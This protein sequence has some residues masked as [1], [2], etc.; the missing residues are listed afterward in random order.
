MVVF[1]KY[2]YIFAVGSVVGW[3]VELLY[4]HFVSNPK[5]NG[6]RKWVNP[7]FLTGPYLP[8]YGFS[9][10]ILYLLSGLD[11]Y[12]SIDNSVLRI[13]VL[14]VMMAICITVIEY[15]A[16][17]I[18]IKRMKIMLWDYSRNRF[19]IQGIICPLYSFFWL[20]L[21]A[22]YYF[23]VYPYFI[24]TVEWL[25]EHIIF[26]FFVGMF[27]GVFILDL[28]QSLQ[29]MIKIKQFAEDNNVVI[30]YEEFKA[31]LRER[32]EGRISSVRAFIGKHSYQTIYNSL[33]EYF[34]EKIKNI[35]KKGK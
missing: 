32:A 33:T 26:C 28:V 8:L 23:A 2:T 4:R 19:N 21:G 31:N 24:T 35:E 22:F 3:L 20:L 1:V 5:V 9:S 25:F 13:I 7:G 34:R 17:M 14:L 11:S 16:G 15:I 18:F 29:I 6:K 10:C 30:I 12:I 27:L